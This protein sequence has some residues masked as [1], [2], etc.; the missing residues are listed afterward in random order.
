MTPNLFNSYRYAGA[1]GISD[2]IIW[3]GASASGNTDVTS[4]FDG[5]AFATTGSLQVPYSKGAGGALLGQANGICVGGQNNSGY[6]N[7]INLFNGSTWSLDSATLSNARGDCW[8][9]GGVQGGASDSGI[10]YGGDGSGLS[11]ATTSCQEFDGTSVS[12][13]GSLNAGRTQASGRGTVDSH[14]CG[15]GSDGGVSFL[16]SY[17][18]Y[19]GSTW[20]SKGNVSTH[21]GR[22]GAG[23][24][25]Q[26]KDDGLTAGGNLTAQNECET[27]NGTNC[28]AIATLNTGLNAPIGG[29]S[30]ESALMMG[31]DTGTPTNIVQEWDNTSWTTISATLNTA[32]SHSNGGAVPA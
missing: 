1:G 14:W 4:V 3:G 17:E 21:S 6:V 8:G 15:L 25:G 10:I 31:G 13:G 28:T 7:Q 18:T 32:V 30:S 5:T 2:A 12:N 26:D 27:F 29:G 19:N 9:S 11:N 16:T 24:A 20:T 22:S 23:G